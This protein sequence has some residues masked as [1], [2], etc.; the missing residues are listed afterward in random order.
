[1]IVG[2][3]ARRYARAIFAVAAEQTTLDQTAAELQL[4]GAVADDPRIAAALANPLL[5]TTA[6]RG[7]AG[8]IADNLKLGPT[9]RNFISLLAD[10]RR[11]NQL[12]GIAREFTHILDQQRQRVRAT[13]TSAVPLDDAQRQALI[14]AFERKLGRT[15]LAETA[16]DPQLLGGVV[17]DVEGTVYDGSVRTQLQSLANRIA[18]GRTLL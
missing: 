8:T 9:T 5:S 3:V 17:V 4:L 16:V 10:H 12:V 13:V 18:G 14:A 1:M 11:L 2:S 15:V 7:L 6:R